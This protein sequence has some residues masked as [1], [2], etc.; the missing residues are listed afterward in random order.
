MD[1]WQCDGDP[2]FVPTVCDL[3]ALEIK[4]ATSEGDILWLMELQEEMKL[5]GC[6]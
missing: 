6:Q 2:N 3:L 5:E 1:V 4:W